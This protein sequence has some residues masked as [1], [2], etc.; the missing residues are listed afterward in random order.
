MDVRT[1]RVHQAY[2]MLRRKGSKPSFARLNKQSLQGSFKVL[3]VVAISFPPP[4]PVSEE[5][6]SPP[7]DVQLNHKGSLTFILTKYL[8]TKIPKEGWY[9]FPFLCL[10]DFFS[11]QVYDQEFGSY[12]FD[13][14]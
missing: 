5:T 6:G 13:T 7:N 14:V 12:A 10:L 8:A 1:F 3:P 11:L 2:A 9:S 4:L